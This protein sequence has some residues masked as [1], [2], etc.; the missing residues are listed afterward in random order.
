[1]S[2]RLWR[3]VALAT[4]VLTIAATAGLVA[5]AGAA[6]AAGSSSVHT[7]TEVGGGAAPSGESTSTRPTGAS[8]ATVNT[9]RQ[10]TDSPQAAEPGAQVLP[11]RMRG[12]EAITA[13]GATLPDVAQ[14]NDLSP[15]RL[16]EVLTEDPTAW[17]SDEG[18]LFYM[19]E[20][21]SAE[22]TT[23]ASTAAAVVAP[24]YPTSE[25]FSLHSRPAASRK[26][27][28]DF[29]GDT[30]Q[31]T[32]WNGSEPGDIANGTHIGYD[33][34]GSPS[35]FST[36]EH[37]FVQEVWRQVSESYAPFDVDVTTA[38]PGVA[39]IVRSSSSDTAYGTHVLITSSPTP[40]QQVCGSC[41][42]VAFVGT[43]DAVASSPYYQPAWVFAYDRSF[44]PM[45]IAQAATHETGHT[46][47]LQHDGTAGMDYYGGTA[48]W[49]PIMGSSRTRAVSQ[50]SA[51]EYTGA[52]NT[53]DDFAVMQTNGLSL[54]VDDHG[55]TMAAADQLG[56]QS[57]YEVK[58]VIENR[59]D[60]DVFA[61]TQNCLKNLTV[62]VA[63]IG[64]QTALD[65]R[66]DVLNGAGTVVATNA[67]PSTYAGTPPASA[68]MDATVTVPNAMGM[69]YLR[70]DG[71][72]TGSPA[73][74]GWS[75]YGSVGQYRLTA[76]GCTVAP[77]APQ[78]VPQPPST[79]Y[80]TPTPS[81]TAN[82]SPTPT[83]PPAAEPNPTP[84]SSP[85]SS[86]PVAAK[87]TRPG[88]PAIRS[89]S[90]GTRGGTVTAVAR[91]SAPTRTGGATIT[92]YRVRAQRLN[93]AGRVVGTYASA[94]LGRS[95]RAVTLR[96]PKGRYV[97]SATALNSAGGSAWSRVSNAVRAR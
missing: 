69:Y 93:R 82:P 31:N 9:R 48:A 24:A 23:T 92:H 68:G 10:G 1:M 65:L 20:E 32:G 41:L 37:G 5:T 44:D 35:T 90:P 67:P 25:T 88:S 15:A 47:G 33:V 22:A 63:G 54:R 60:T 95:A 12:P 38:D 85:P 66:L 8:K 64:A 29:D 36:A 87:P 84:P 42:G 56:A 43:F 86:P 39:G 6:P 53:E 52:S 55:S 72:G 34:D 57:S 13:L 74:P 73:G 96:L 70:V 50:F 80:P 51:G 14:D 17:L 78:A 49:G 79:P 83:S 28:L 77:V 81:P 11:R 21:A 75:D 91:W 4:T 62:S 94:Y 89:A 71:V 19:E 30:V 26:V 18:Q 27:F 61:I 58:G 45:I 16:T 7:L 46:L 40:R 3:P 97:F 59:T 76:Q 2:P